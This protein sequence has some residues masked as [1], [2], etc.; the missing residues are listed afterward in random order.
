[1]E[2]ATYALKKPRKLTFSMKK[3]LF[4]IETVELCRWA[5]ETFK[6]LYNVDVFLMPKGE[7][8][9]TATIRQ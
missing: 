3:V 1:M 2:V 6:L 5:S 9:R 8:S 4:Y 7:V